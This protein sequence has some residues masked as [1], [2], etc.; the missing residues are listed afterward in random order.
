MAKKLKN[1]RQYSIYLN[2][3]SRVVNAIAERFVGSIRKEILDYF[4]IF[5]ES[6]LRNILKEYFEYYNEIRPHQAE[7]ALQSSIEQR[8]PEGYDIRKDGKIRF[9]SILFGLNQECYQVAA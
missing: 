9:R 2:F 7:G 1:T 6:Q 8:I 5:S 4:I 3:N